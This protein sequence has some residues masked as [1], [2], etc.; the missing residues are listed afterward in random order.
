MRKQISGCSINDHPMSQRE[1]LSTLYIAEEKTG[2]SGG[3]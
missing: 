1:S 3:T 2:F